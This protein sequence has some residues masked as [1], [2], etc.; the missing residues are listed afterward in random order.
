[1]SEQFNTI[2]PL[3]QVLDRFRYKGILEGFVGPRWWRGGAEAFVWEISGGRSDVCDAVRLAL[4]EMTGAQLEANE[5]LEPIVCVDQNYEPIAE[6]V[7]IDIAVRIQPDDWPSYAE[8]A[9]TTIELA[10]A[11]AEVHALVVEADRLRVEDT[12]LSREAGRN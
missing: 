3:A 8:Q 11:N 4:N 7:S 10:R 9:W 5:I 12:V 2:P 1:L 6:P